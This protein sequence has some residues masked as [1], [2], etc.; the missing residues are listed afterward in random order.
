M[1]LR[2]V[3]LCMACFTLFASGLTYGVKFLRKRNYLLGLEWLVVGFS[4]AN[5]LV[6][7]ST[8]SESA[9]LIAYFC[10]AFSRGFGIPI[11][12]VLGLM[13]VT[14]GYKPSALKDVLIF[15]GA[16]AATLV[17]ISVPSLGR[18]LPYFYVSMWGVFALYLLYFACRLASV[19]ETRQ[20]AGVMLGMLASLTIAA[21]YDF[22]KIPGDETNVLL[23][24]YVLALSTWA[25]V[26]VQ[27]YYAYGALERAK[28]SQPLL[29]PR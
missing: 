27:L 28:E 9:Y 8:Q 29:Q 17:L 15:T 4:A 26:L 6:Y 25:Y 1:E 16:I 23:N 14:H 3:V 24:F 20:A 7:F 22:Y 5:F 18:F 10:D 2:N 11:I 21:I 12:T 19:G 13:A